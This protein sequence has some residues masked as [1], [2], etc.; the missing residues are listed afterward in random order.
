MNIIDNLN[1]QKMMDA[2]KVF[3]NHFLDSKSLYLYH[4]NNL[5]SIHFIGGIDGEKA[6]KAFKESFSELIISELQYRWYKKKKRGYQYDVTVFIMKNNTIVEMKHYC[7]ILH[8][9]NNIEFLDACTALMCR[10]K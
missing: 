4:F 3:S 2:A 6:Y 7:E 9:G 10:F 5:P 1:N 8:D